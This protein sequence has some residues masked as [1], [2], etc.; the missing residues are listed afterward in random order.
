MLPCSACIRQALHKLP[1]HPESSRSLYL[2]TSTIRCPSPILFRNHSTIHSIRT[3]HHRRE[4]LKSIRK[5]KKTTFPDARPSKFLKRALA[6]EK[7]ELA[8]AHNRARLL[9]SPHGPGVPSNYEASVL[10]DRVRLADEVLKSLQNDKL[11]KALD[12]CRAS[13]RSIDGTPP[14]NST[15]SWNHVIDWLMMRKDPGRAWSVFNEVRKSI[16]CPWRRFQS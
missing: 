4:L 2:R 14:V 9:K 6:Q 11:L 3:G 8:Q 12:L 13:E 1:I 5:P 10:T 7:N 16:K 15:V